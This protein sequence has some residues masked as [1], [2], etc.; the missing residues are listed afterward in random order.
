MLVRG[1]LDIRGLRVHSGLD[2]PEIQKP[3]QAGHAGLQGQMLP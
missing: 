3:V 2:P 1:Q